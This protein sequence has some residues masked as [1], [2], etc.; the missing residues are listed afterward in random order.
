VQQ[1]QMRTESFAP[2]PTLRPFIQRFIV[3]EYSAG[4]TTKLLPGAGIVAAFR[5]KGQCLINGSSAPNAL[6]T[7][8]LDQ[9]RV[10]AHSDGCAN[11]I[12]MFTPTG[13]AAFLREPVANLFNGA[14]PFEQQV[15]SSHLT[16]IEEQLAGSPDNA[17]RVKRLEQFLLTEL[18]PPRTDSLVAAAVAGIHRLRGSLRIAALAQVL[19]FSQSTLE[20]RF[21]SAVGASPKKFASVVRLRYVVRLRKGGATF[22]NIAHAAGYTDQAHFIKDFRRLA[23]ESP[24]SFFRSSTG[25]C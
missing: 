19:G 8:L 6:V 12:A 24:E 23:G 9:A 21:Y 4:Q 16:L 3:V 1:T 7:G 15:R 10:L 22:T 20:R 2:S 14:M 11:V 18:R 13:A 25:F 5:F 17:G